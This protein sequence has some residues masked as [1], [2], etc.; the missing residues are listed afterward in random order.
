MLELTPATK[1]LFVE[2]VKD[3]PNWGGTPLFQG[4][5]AQ[6]GNLTDLKTKGLVETEQDE[7]NRLCFWVYFTDEGK[8][9]A[10]DLLQVS[11]DYFKN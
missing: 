2:L 11:P 6:Q 1:A 9:L 3:A 4:T 5:K 8:K 10:V 7:D